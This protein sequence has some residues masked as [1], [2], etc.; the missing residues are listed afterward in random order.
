MDLEGSW[1]T[2]R[3]GAK[4][5]IIMFD[6]PLVGT[7]YRQEVSWGDAEDAAEVLSNDY[8][9]GSDPDLDQLVPQELA[10]LLCADDCVVTREFTPIEPG[11]E[12]RKYYAP[13]I[14]LFLEVNL[15]E[16]ETVQIVGC[17]VHPACASLPEIEQD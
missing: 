5:G 13:G 16:D 8:G 6:F 12:E 4:P 17:N 15:E 9:Y 7:I 11:G 10:E 14:G 3:D 2:G 1:K